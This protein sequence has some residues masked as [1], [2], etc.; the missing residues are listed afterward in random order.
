VNPLARARVERRPR[1]PTGATAARF[2]RCSRTSTRPLVNPLS[3][4]SSRPR[5]LLRLLQ[6]NV[7]TSTTGDP[8]NTPT[9]E[10]AA[11][12]TARSRP[13]CLDRGQSPK[14]LV[15]R[16]RGKPLLD[17]PRGDCSS[18]RLGPDLDRSGRLLS[19]P[20]LSRPVRSDA[21]REGYRHRIARLHGSRT[22]G[23]CDAE[24]PRRNPTFTNPR[25]LPSRDRSRTNEGSCR[26][27]S[28]DAV[29]RRLFHRLR[30]R[31][32]D[33]RTNADSSANRMRKPANQLLVDRPQ[34]PS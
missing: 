11:G 6:I 2:H 4:V 26:S 3:R 12:T 19:R 25:H 5:A 9:T 18:R 22:T 34:R 27:A 31:T 10:S 29:R 1:W 17:V 24:L 13:S 32:G 16:G 20:S 14:R 23:P 28:R 8:T 7:S 21:G 30:A 33:A 15:V